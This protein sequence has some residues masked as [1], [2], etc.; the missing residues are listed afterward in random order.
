[1]GGF[2]SGQFRARKLTV[3]ECLCLDIN[4]LARQ[5]IF[6]QKQ[7]KGTLN[8]LDQETRIFTSS[9]VIRPTH[10][11]RLEYW[12]EIR[13]IRFP[14]DE[15][16]TLTTTKLNSGGLRWW[17]RCLC[18]Q[19]AGKLYLPPDQPQFKCRACYNLTYRSCQKK[20]KYK[21]LFINISR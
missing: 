18:G 10:H 17:F 12:I 21:R 16:I 6:R 11:L 8:W 20:D 13:G 19:R 9:Y 2:G 1:M 5:G 15:T 3:E 4:Q 14:K 7:N